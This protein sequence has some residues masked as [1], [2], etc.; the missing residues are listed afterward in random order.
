MPLV[1]VLVRR[2]RSRAVDQESRTRTT[3]EDEALAIRHSEFGLLSS[4]VLRAS[5]FPSNFDTLLILRRENCRLGQ[6]LLQSRRKG[7]GL[8]FLAMNDRDALDVA[9]QSLHIL[10]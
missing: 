9:F 1:L 3:D 4:F 8:A 6:H 7:H 2:P 10:N 5:S